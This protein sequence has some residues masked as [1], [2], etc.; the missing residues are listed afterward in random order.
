MRGGSGE[1]SCQGQ[2]GRAA[3]EGE[4][5]ARVRVGVAR[6]GGGLRV[7]D[8]VEARRV[9]RDARQTL[10]ANLRRSVQGPVLRRHPVQPPAR[11]GE[12]VGGGRGRPRG[13]I[14]G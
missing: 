14:D 7:L 11:L 6:V 8:L 5:R 4:V 10:L 13:G 9:Q 1:G 2:G 3:V 12:V